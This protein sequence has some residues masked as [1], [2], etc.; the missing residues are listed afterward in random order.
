M[1]GIAGFSGHFDPQLLPKMGSL[2][3]HRGPDDAGDIYI[4]HAN[5]I[6]GL[7][8]QRLAIIDL[9]KEGK[10]PMTV[11]CQ[12]CQ[13]T[14]TTNNEHKIWLTYNGEIYNYRE[15]RAELESKGHQFFSHTDSEV[16]IHLY[17][18]E[19]VEM[20]SRLNGI[21]A[22]ALFDGRL[23]GHK[24]NIQSGDLILARDGVGTKPLYYSQTQ[25]GF[26]FASEIKALL[27]SQELQREI[28]TT[29]MHYYLAYLWCP[30]EQTALRAVKKLQPG[31]TIVVRDHQIKKRWFYYDIPYGRETHQLSEEDICIELDKQLTAAVERQLVADVP[32]GAFLSGGLDSSAVVAMMRKINPEKK[33]TCYSIGFSKGISIDGNPEDLPYA[34]QVA[35]HLNVDLHVL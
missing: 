15:L 6:V 13:S 34:K 11:D 2:I 33:I 3:S 22:F 9:T 29:A 20:L 30:G 4:R 31:E 32:V 7:A 23:Q 12:C 17:A 28:D 27:A 16:L 24:G 1:C 5:Q 18:E 21:F 26:L 35:K 8:H 19:G 25:S 14:K 10:Q